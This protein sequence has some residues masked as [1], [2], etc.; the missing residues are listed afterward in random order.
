MPPDNS[1]LDC[2]EP[3]A[4]SPGGH[5]CTARKNIAGHFQDN[6]FR[7]EGGSISENKRPAAPRAL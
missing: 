7:R 6:G 2:S 4:R 5:G 1:P 3:A